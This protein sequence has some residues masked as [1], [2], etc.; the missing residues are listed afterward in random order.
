[1]TPEERRNYIGRFIQIGIGVTKEDR[2]QPCRMKSP[3]TGVLGTHDAHIA[4]CFEVETVDSNGGK[5]V[6]TRL[7]VSIHH[8]TA[9]NDT[10]VI[11]AFNDPCWKLMFPPVL[12]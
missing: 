5:K 1:M 4:D 12:R 2:G 6:E 11:V 9:Q 3:H 7:K 8:G 10:T